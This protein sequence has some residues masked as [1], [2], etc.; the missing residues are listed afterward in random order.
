MASWSTFIFKSVSPV[1]ASKAVFSKK[2]RSCQKN[3]IT[4]QS[5]KEQLS[6]TSKQTFIQPKTIETRAKMDT[7]LRFLSALLVTL[8]ASSGFME[9]KKTVGLT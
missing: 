5:S 7:V 6:N 3:V 4:W 1:F 9:E 8:K 2:V